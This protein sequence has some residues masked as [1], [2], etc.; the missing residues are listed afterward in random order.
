M[1]TP[2]S[3]SNF[4]AGQEEQRRED[5]GDNSRGL[6]SVSSNNPFA[7]A[8]NMNNTTMWNPFLAN[9]TL[10]MAQQPQGMIQPGFSPGPGPS[11]I[12]TAMQGQGHM[13]YPNYP[14]YAYSA[15]P[16]PYYPPTFP[17]PEGLAPSTISV[18]SNQPSTS[19]SGVEKPAPL[20]FPEPDVK[21]AD[22]SSTSAAGTSKESK[23]EQKKKRRQERRAQENR[24]VNVLNY[25]GVEVPDPALPRCALN[26]QKVKG[27]TPKQDFTLFVHYTRHDVIASDVMVEV[28]VDLVLRLDVMRMDALGDYCV[29]KTGR[30]LVETVDACSVNSDWKFAFKALCLGPIGFDVE[31]IR[32]AIDGFSNKEQLLV[33]VI[34]GR[35]ASEIKLLKTWYKAKYGSD[36]V[37]D[38]RS[39]LSAKVE[40][41]FSMALAAQKA[42]NEPNCLVDDK[43]VAKDVKDLYEA[44]KKKDETPFFEILFNR[45]DLH[46]RAIVLAFGEKHDKNLS[47][48]IKK[49]FSGTVEMALL[50]IVQGIKPKRDGQGRWRDAK[51]LEKSMAGL[52]TRT[53][54]LSYR[55]IRAHWDPE[56]LEAIKFSY[57][58]KYKRT[59][60]SRIKGETS[61]IY[62][63][64][65]LSILKSAAVRRLQEST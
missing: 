2:G 43:Q 15:P 16:P 10:S 3:S 53:T 54:Q 9:A 4:N 21:V 20:S 26:V 58:W 61:G 18:P 13:G 41:L 5:G 55:L 49:A 25:L 59:L 28:L 51:L 12:P 46:L 37:N 30:T 57:E 39:D 52:G 42:V 40:K 6:F 31:L 48:T 23:K 19:H 45:S 56:R 7:S 27:Y 47:K 29:A 33:E 44:A 11:Y 24:L 8:L 32:K 65:L 64:L 38:I 60:E 63:K 14:Q 17:Q 50:H 35:Q 62:G 22:S 34:V 1:T 36:L